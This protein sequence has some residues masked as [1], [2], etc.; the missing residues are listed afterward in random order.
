MVFSIKFR[1]FI[2]NIQSPPVG[3]LQSPHPTPDPLSLNHRGSESVSTRAMAS[4]L[5]VSWLLVV[6]ASE[7]PEQQ[8]ERWED[9]D[10]RVC[11]PLTHSLLGY[12]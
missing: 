1:F 11:V 2:H 10:T 7:R 9:K 3:S 5:L 12:S 8:I 4:R 6:F